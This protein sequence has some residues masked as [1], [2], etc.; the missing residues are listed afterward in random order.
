MVMLSQERLLEVLTAQ[1]LLAWQR[2]PD[3]HDDLAAALIDVLREQDKGASE[4]GRRDG[5]K[6]IIEA[7]GGKVLGQQ[8]GG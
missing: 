8:D 4:R 2:A 3:Y 5:V 7:L 6:R 1:V